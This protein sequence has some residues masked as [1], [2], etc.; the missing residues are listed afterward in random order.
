MSRPLPYRNFKWVEPKYYAEKKEGIGM[1]YEVDLEY[2]IELHHL[3]NDYPCAAEKIKVTDEMLSGY[4]KDIKNKFKISSGNVHKLISTLY[5]KEKY[6]LHEE[7][8]KLYLSLGLLLKRVHRVLQFDEK[9][10]LKEYID[11]NTE[12]RKNAK[13]SFEKD[14]FKLMNNS[15]FGKTMENIRKRCNVYLETDPDHFLRQTAKP[16]YVSCKIF[17]ENLVAVNMKKQRLKLDKPS[18]VG[19]CILD[20]SK[21]LMYAFHYNYIKKKY[22]GKAKLLFTDTDSLCYI[23]TT[24]DV[25][26]DLY[27]DR[28]LFDNS[29][30]AESS[31]FF[32]DENKKVIGKFKDEAGGNAIIEFV[33]L[34][35]KMYSYKTETK[36]KKIYKKMYLLVNNTK[37]N[38]T[39]KGVK[40]NVIK[41]DLDHSHYLAC[42]QNNTVEQH[43]IRTIRSDHHV[44]SSY[45]INKTSLSCFDDKR[46]ILHDGITSYAYGHNLIKNEK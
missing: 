41:R 30:Y 7:N 11:F 14:Y 27:H 45:E 34:K 46:Y 29:D 24:G 12:M 22:G 40:K 35:S 8:L 1:I 9:P 32:F 33:G 6:V 10:W 26:E 3:H 4:C 5:D 2:P 13:N 21:V 43:K 37:N 19:M 28:E 31:K 17:H 15:V 23:I 44:I 16:T 42:L 20:L 38:K 39:A 25:Y 18:Y 36:R